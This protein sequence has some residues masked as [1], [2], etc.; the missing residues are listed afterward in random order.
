MP[1]DYI[2][3]EFLQPLMDEVMR[4][5]SE[6]PERVVE[7]CKD[8]IKQSEGE[9]MYG[10]AFGEYFYAEACYRLNLPEELLNHAVKG[11]TIQ[12]TFG[13]FELETRTYNLLGAYFVTTGELQTALGYYLKG[14]EL[15]TQNNMHH[16]VKIFN[17]NFGDL[18][19]RQKDYEK[20]IYYFNQTNVLVDEHSEKMMTKIE[21]E[22]SSMRYGNL[23]EAYLHLGEFQKAKDTCNELLLS[24]NESYYKNNIAMFY[25]I[26]TRVNYVLGKH[27]QGQSSSMLFFRCIM[28]KPDVTLSSDVYLPMGEFFIERGLLEEADCLLKFM[29]SIEHQLISPYQRVE[30]CKLY[31]EYYKRTNETEYLFRSYEA[32]YEANLDYEIAMEVEKRRNMQVQIELHDAIK[33][34]HNMMERNME[35]ERLSEHDELTGLANRYSMNKYCEQMFEEACKNNFRFGVIIVDIDY[36]KEYNDTYGHIEGDHCIRSVAHI[37]KQSAENLLTARFGGDEFLVMALNVE[38]EFMEQTANRI[39]NNIRNLRIEH[40]GSKISTFVTVSQGIVNTI[41]SNT[42]TVFDYIH[43]ADIA[44]YKIKKSERNSYGFYID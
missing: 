18:Y 7:L 16:I 42:D 22:L 19:L 4:I 31:I 6:N 12:K 43:M 37:I 11:L 40:S 35:L 29:K 10:N 36:F 3:E 1:T 20:A 38:D 5:R 21:E 9:Y 2:K 15:A 32:Y 24:L 17:N 13:F 44:L 41:P 30:L 28:E 14:A 27:E 26:L 25:S 39:R 8:I 34:Q 23:I 33:T